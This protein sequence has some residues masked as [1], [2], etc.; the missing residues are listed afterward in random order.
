MLL[1]KHN[2]N[3]AKLAPKEASR[4]NVN[5]IRV[6]PNET[7]VTDGHYMM[8]VSTV[9]L[10]A[11]TFPNNP[12]SGLTVRDDFAPFNLNA[13]AALAAAASLP[14]RTPIPVLGC[15]AVAMNGDL[16]PKLLTTDLEQVQTFPA[17]EGSF[18]DWQRVMPKAD[19]M[20][21]VIGLDARLL[22]PLLEQFIAFQDSKR[23]PAVVDF[24]FKD[25]RSAILMTTRTD[26][27][28]GQTMTAVLM[29]TRI[30]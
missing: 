28:D 4:F 30:N 26:R 2:L 25:A 29:P 17:D 18:P 11:D 9:A 23:Q 13:K 3:I 14:K 24:R 21:F 7:V 5:A 19:D 16:K 22:R 1:N 6:T 10:S 15:A 8:V 27:S 12:D 20:P